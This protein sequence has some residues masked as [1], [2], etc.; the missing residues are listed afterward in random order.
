MLYLIAQTLAVAGGL[1]MTALALMTVVSVL[2]RWLFS[3]PIDGDF[4]LISIGTALAVF[5]FLPYCHMRRGNVLVDLFLAWTPQR[6]QSALD[7][8]SGLL[9]A[10]LAALLGWRTIY[11]GIEVYTYQETSYI[12]AL[13]TWWGYPMAVASLFLLSLCCLYTAYADLR[14]VIQ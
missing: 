2:G 12:L 6:F 1:I 5:M 4:E 8:A 13:P 14:R 3:K 9:F 11:G 7:V 10:A